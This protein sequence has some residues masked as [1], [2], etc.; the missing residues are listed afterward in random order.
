LNKSPRVF[1]GH[2]EFLCR[3]V[4]GS[5]EFPAALGFW[6]AD[7][8]PRHSAAFPGS[9]A[10]IHPARSGGVAGASARARRRSGSRGRTAESRRPRVLTPAPAAPAHGDGAPP[11]NSPRFAAN[12]LTKSGC[13]MSSALSV[14]NR[15]NSPDQAGVGHV[16]LLHNGGLLRR[17]VTG[18]AAD[19]RCRWHGQAALRTPGRGGQRL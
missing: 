12:P 19:S 14:G 10:D 4:P 15:R 16:R 7:S 6:L 2:G 5:G 18:R 11:A 9:G 3:R 1:A 17:A 13:A 8:G